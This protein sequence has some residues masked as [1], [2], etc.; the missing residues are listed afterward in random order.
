MAWTTTASNGWIKNSETVTV[1]DS[2]GTYNSSALAL[3][4]GG[5]IMSSVEEETGLVGKIQYSVDDAVVG[6]VG[7][8]GA[9]P[10]SSI[11]STQTWVDLEV[12]ANVGDSILETYQLPQS[13]RQVRVQYT[14]TAASYGGDL[15][16][17]VDIY[18]NKK[19]SDIGFSISGIGADPS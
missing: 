15:G 8:V 5:T 9:D 3:L 14:V 18:T 2:D 17:L 13:C 4:G 6:A 10:S 12:A 1:V 16:H 19:K 7:G 11:D